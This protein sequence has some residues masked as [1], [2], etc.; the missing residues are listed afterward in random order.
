MAAAPKKI[1]Q[2]TCVACRTKRD[3]KDLM[4]IVL[5]PEG[6][7]KYD[8]T[9]RAA[10][11]GSYLCKNEECLKQAAKLAKG[12]RHPLTSEDISGILQMANGSDD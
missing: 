5:T 12:L 9:G 11:R 7:I 4:R 2:R 3:K 1:P 8:P 6:E 10:G